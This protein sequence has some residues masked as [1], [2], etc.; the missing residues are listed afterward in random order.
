[1]ITILSILLGL[2][3]V[4]AFFFFKKEKINFDERTK[5]EV[6]QDLKKQDKNIVVSIGP[7]LL[8]SK[9]NY[10]LYAL[11]SISNKSLELEQ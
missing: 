6:Y 2:Y 7:S 5:F 9:D 11:S 4:N 10:P 1:M 8:G 3:I